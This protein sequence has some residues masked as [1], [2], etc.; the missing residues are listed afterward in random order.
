MTIRC[1]AIFAALFLWIG[2]GQGL[3][4]DVTLTSRDGSVEISGDIL[5]YDGEFYRRHL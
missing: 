1:A 3:A 5:G 2:A 4:E